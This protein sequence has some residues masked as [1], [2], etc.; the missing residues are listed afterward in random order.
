MIEVKMTEDTADRLLLVAGTDP[1][2]DHPH[3]AA[4]TITVMTTTMVVE[5]AMMTDIEAAEEEKE[6]ETA[7]VEAEAEVQTTDQTSL[8]Q[9][10]IVHWVVCGFALES[11]S[12]LRLVECMASIPFQSWPC[13]GW[14]E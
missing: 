1:D 13:I 9:W 3:V 2:P 10:S 11:L 4:D 14:P 8:R 6:E 5:S 7:K 12:F